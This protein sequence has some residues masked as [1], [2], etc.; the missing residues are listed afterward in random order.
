MQ[1]IARYISSIIDDGS[2][3]QIGLGRF[4]T[5]ALALLDDR[6]DLG[7]HSDV[8]TDAIV[9]LLEKGVLTGRM[10]SQHRAKIVAS[11]AR[12]SRRL[13]ALIDR[14]PLF[15]FQ[16]LDVVCDPAVLAAQ[17]KLCLLYTSRCV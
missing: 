6:K 17:H 2:T 12:G 4:S 1:A 16:R 14:N 11:F 5:A 13:H 15:V 7:V 8:I 9:P 10:K 3:L